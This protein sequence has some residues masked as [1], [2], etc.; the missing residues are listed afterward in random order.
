MIYKTFGQTGKQVSAVGFGGMRF[1]MSQ[2]PKK[3]AELLLYAREKGINY[4]DTAPKYCNDK[5]EDIFGIALKQMKSVRDEI[6]VSTKGSPSDMPTA[7]KAR[8]AVEKSLKRMK[9]D[10]LDF[11]FVWCIRKL[12]HFELAIRKGGQ[13]EGLLKCKEEG[14]IDHIVVSTHLRGSEIVQMLD[15]NYFE[16]VLMGVNILNFPYRWDGVQK[17]HESGLGV[18]AMNPL[19]GGVIPQHEDKLGFL[20]GEHETPTEAALRF[21]IGCPEI[22]VTLVGFSRR[23][24]IDTACRIADNCRPLDAA[25]IHRIREHV[26]EN[27]DSLCTGCGYCLASCAQNIPVASYMQFYNEKLLTD[28]SEAQTIESLKIHLDWGV[29]VDRAAE[30]AD[31][32][33][34]GQCEE[35]CTQHL[36]IM[37]RLRE[38]AGWEKHVKEQ[39]SKK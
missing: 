33:E 34:C 22:T 35:A 24:H 36:N 7:D 8:K 20:A 10:K 27:M 32:I 26:A 38:L 12:E 3:N 15:K 37:E 2:P 21:C 13:Y 39:K 25:D 9:V 1:D 5:S 4:F 16:G 29:L 31:C 23:E 19:A 17:A 18:L 6:Y 11:Y 14:L 30:S 28:K